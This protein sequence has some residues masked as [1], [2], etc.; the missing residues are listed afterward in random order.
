[1]EMLTS[2]TGIYIDTNTVP[3][4]ELPEYDPRS[5]AH[6][7]AMFG[8]WKIDPEKITM[9]GK[10]YLD[11]ENLMSIQ[12]PACLFCEQLY[13]PYLATRRCKGD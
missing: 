6:F 10:S 2:G 4:K 1:M 11:H 7:W 3:K 12:G 9:G 8:V 5:G 13:T